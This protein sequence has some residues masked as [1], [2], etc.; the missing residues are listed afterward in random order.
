MPLFFLICFLNY[1]I[2]WRKSFQFSHQNNQSW[3]VCCF[4]FHYFSLYHEGAEGTL[5]WVLVLSSSKSTAEC[6][7]LSCSL[8]V[9]GYCSV[10]LCIFTSL[11]LKLCS[12]WER[13][14]LTVALGVQQQEEGKTSNF[15]AERWEHDFAVMAQSFLQWASRIINHH[16]HYLFFFSLKHLVVPINC[17]SL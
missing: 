1:Q 7:F 3:F 10:H 4:R 17:V 5:A 2:P 6:E 14:V 8:Q 11:C 12:V 16:I 15:R 9:Q 13:L